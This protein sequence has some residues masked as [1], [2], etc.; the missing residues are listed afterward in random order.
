MNICTGCA[1]CA[2]FTEIEERFLRLVFEEAEQSRQL[3]ETLLESLRELS[4]VEPKE[5]P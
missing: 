3:T 1:R 5:L 4:V 2:D